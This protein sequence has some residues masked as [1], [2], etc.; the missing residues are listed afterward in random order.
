MHTVKQCHMQYTAKPAEVEVQLMY[1]R[2]LLGSSMVVAIYLAV[3]SLRCK[4]QQQGTPPA[5]GPSSCSQPEGVGGV[6]EA[7]LADADGA[8]G[9]L[10]AAA[11]VA[12]VGGDGERDVN[13]LPLR[14]RV[15]AGAGIRPHG[16]P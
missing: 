4:H 10:V 1:Y 3:Q 7:V 5:S 2:M 11:V 9:K 14:V 12:V 6:V 13:L 16:M 15:C 8:H